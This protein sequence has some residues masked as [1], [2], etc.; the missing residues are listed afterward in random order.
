GHHEN[1]SFHTYHPAL[2]IAVSKKIFYYCYQYFLKKFFSPF[3]L[4]VSVSVSPSPDEHDLDSS[5]IA[6]NPACAPPQ[7]EM[8][9]WNE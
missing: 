5:P 3:S 6:Y 8:V 4:V 2:I 1:L 7:M 9:F